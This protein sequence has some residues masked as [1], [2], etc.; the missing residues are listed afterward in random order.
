MSKQ[1]VEKL[2]RSD[3]ERCDWCGKDQQLHTYNITGKASDVS[4]IRA[5]IIV[6]CSCCLNVVIKDQIAE[7]KLFIRIA[8]REQITLEEI[9]KSL[10][11]PIPINLKKFE[12]EKKHLIDLL[13]TVNAHVGY[14]LQLN[15]QEK[16]IAFIRADILRALVEEAKMTPSE[17]AINIGRN[18][19]YVV[20]QL[21]LRRAFPNAIADDN[22]L[23]LDHYMVASK[24]NYPE[25]WLL[26]AQ[27]KGLNPKELK[28]LIENDDV[29]I[30]VDK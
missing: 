9:Y 27:E 23:L 3:V 16:A 14:L 29:F 25:D 26:K 20:E 22:T 21:K 19:K 5:E 11:M 13:M 10:Q 2:S 4:G 15:Q 18:K 28:N 1:L 24:V 17:V 6:L 7:E 12:E 8:I 30:I